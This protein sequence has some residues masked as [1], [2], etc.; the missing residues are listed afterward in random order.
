MMCHEGKCVPEAV[1]K[2]DSYCDSLDSGAA[3]LQVQPSGH[4]AMLLGT[5]ISKLPLHL[6]SPL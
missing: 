3:A 4:I 2:K 5:S 1:E 6:L